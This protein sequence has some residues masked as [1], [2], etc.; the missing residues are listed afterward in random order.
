MAGWAAAGSAIGSLIGGERRNRANAKEARRNREFQER[1]SN[2]AYQRAMADMRAAGL[3][4]IL[5]GKLGGA[6]S[7]GGSMAVFGDSV[8][9][10]VNTG[11]QAMQVGSNVDKQDAEIAKVEQEISNLQ[12]AKNL[13]DE[14]VK[15]TA[16][17]ISKLSS[18]I[19]NIKA[20]TEGVEQV[21]AIKK[22]VVKF[23]ED[24]NLA[25]MASD[26]G[27]TI[28]Q[29]INVFGE[30]LGESAADVQIG[31]ENLLNWTRELLK[32]KN[33]RNK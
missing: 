14:Q 19:D 16:I 31:A 32:T 11:L 24:G 8:T 12:S 4:P 33:R 3:N 15:Q 23:V 29:T 27:T 6:S 5:A 26:S 22:V 9:P 17:S 10:A 25:Q 30:W 20:R 21:N 7:P 2:T 13:T 28:S 18:E 1:M